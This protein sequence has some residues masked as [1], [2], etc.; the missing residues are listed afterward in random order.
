MA[1]A[2]RPLL[3]Y[4]RKRNFA[5]TPEPRGRLPR[6][7]NGSA[8]FVVHLHHARQRHFDLR[9]QVGKLGRTQGTVA[10]SEQEVTCGAGGKSSSRV[11][12]FRGRHPA[13]PVRGPFTS[14]DARSRI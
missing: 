1:A 2:T 9:L 5:A 10:R 13:G 11:R 6:K 7:A 3:L 12:G 14:G 8:H 4:R